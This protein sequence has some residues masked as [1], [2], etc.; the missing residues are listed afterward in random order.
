MKTVLIT[1]ANKGIGFE[2]ARQLLQKQFRV[3]LCGRDAGR[4]QQAVSDLGAGDLCLPLVMDVGDR[5]AIRRG[6]DELRTAGIPLDVLIN[7]A[8]VLLKED[9]SL[10][11]QAASIHDTTFR[12]N[13]FGP[14]EV[15]RQFLPLMRAPGRI[16][17]LSSGGG[18]MT[19]PVGGW[20]PAYC[21]SKSALNGITRQLAHELQS[22]GIVVNA[23]CPGWVQ[24]DMGGSGAPRVVRKGAE[25]PVWLASEADGRTTGKFFR[26]KQVIPW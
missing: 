2:T 5:E 10:S 14:L 20:S 7:N 23:V 4:V 16:I 15:V 17:N 6:A 12:I 1:G 25:T 19:D 26:D 21:A 18:S 13:V 8:A 9:Q 3:I 11:T 22:K 24:T